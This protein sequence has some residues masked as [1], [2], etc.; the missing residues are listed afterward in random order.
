MPWRHYQR[1]QTLRRR[2]AA[3]LAFR[4]IGRSAAELSKGQYGQSRGTATVLTEHRRPGSW[5]RGW[6]VDASIPRNALLSGEMFS[7]NYNEALCPRRTMPTFVTLDSFT[8]V[9][10]RERGDPVPTRRYRVREPASGPPPGTAGP[11][12]VPRRQHARMA[13]APRRA[14]IPAFG[15][16]GT[17]FHIVL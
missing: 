13:G 16:G 3:L 10:S 17:N 9:S 2:S 6:A 15:F 5:Q 12:K 14:G 8:S 11:P 7:D 4:D 1:P